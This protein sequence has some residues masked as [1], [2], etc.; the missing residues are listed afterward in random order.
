MYEYCNKLSIIQSVLGLINF[1]VQTMLEMKSDNQS[2]IEMIEAAANMI[3]L[4]MKHKDF[5]K[6]FLVFNFHEYDGPFLE[7]LSQSFTIPNSNF[8]H[9]RLM[10]QAYHSINIEEYDNGQQYDLRGME[11]TLLREM[12]AFNALSKSRGVL[13]LAPLFTLISSIW[14]RVNIYNNADM[15]FLNICELHKLCAYDKT[16]IKL[17]IPSFLDV[18]KV[19]QFSNLDDIAATR[20]PNFV[21][22]QNNFLYNIT[23]KST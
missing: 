5:L 18:G 13:H 3:I 15:A 8:Q 10:V 4:Y 16:L 19:A 11:I 9:L 17:S 1:E 14:F 22:K 21:K 6:R 12:S 23:I 7:S 20:V 2:I